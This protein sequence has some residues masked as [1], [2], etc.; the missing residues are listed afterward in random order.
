MKVLLLNPPGS[1]A[2]HLRDYYCAGT[3]KSSY[4]YHPVDLLYL[5]GML[6]MLWNT[7]KT[8]A[9]G[10]AVSVQVPAAPAHA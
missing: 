9:A 2:N 1:G 4:Y 8:A 7:V 6:I 10:H 5:S 3:T